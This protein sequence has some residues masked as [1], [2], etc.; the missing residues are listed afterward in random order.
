MAMYLSPQVAV[1]EIDLST[2]IP[3]VATSIGALV[4]RDTYKGPELKQTL[5]TSENELIDIFGKPR[6]RVYDHD[7]VGSTL[8]NCY[9][10]IFSAIGYLKYGNKLYCTRVMSPSATFAGS[11]LDPTDT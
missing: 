5:I 10:D 8:S 11:V 9:R 1:Q 6:K 7:G 4:L 3:A 2:T